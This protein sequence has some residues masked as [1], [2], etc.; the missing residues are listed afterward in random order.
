VEDNNSQKRP[1]LLE[2]EEQKPG[3]APEK[4]FHSAAFA[5]NDHFPTSVHY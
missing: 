4:G 1:I 5:E 3:G 2:E